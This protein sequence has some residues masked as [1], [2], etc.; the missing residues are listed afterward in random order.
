MTKNKE[1]ENTVNAGRDFIKGS[2][3]LMCIPIAP[4]ISAVIPIAAYPTTSGK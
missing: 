4:D 1:S 2:F 3:T